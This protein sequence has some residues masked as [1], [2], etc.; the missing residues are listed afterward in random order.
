MKTYVNKKRAEKLR[1][2]ICK[3]RGKEYDI[4]YPCY[5]SL[6]LDGELN[7]IRKQGNL[8]YSMNKTKYG[9]FRFDY[10]ALKELRKINMPDGFYLVEIYYG[11]GRIKEDFYDF[12]RNKK[13][14]D[15]RVGIWGISK[16]GNDV[17][18]DTTRTYEILGELKNKLNGS[19]FAS[20][21]PY[22]QVNNRTELDLL[23][24]EY[25]YNKGYEGLVIRNLRGIWSEGNTRRFI[26]V[27]LK[28]REIDTKN[29]NGSKIKFR[30]E[31]YG[32]WLENENV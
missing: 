12:L 1:L 20:I 27:K 32:L 4:K 15:L 18:V 30:F 19:K 17:N 28:S 2:S 22:W 3:F 10:K 23:I 7:Y 24:K 9:R 25:I 13:S 21:T 8:I 16:L 5:V 14:D 29:K 31:K 11:E 6:K 26:K